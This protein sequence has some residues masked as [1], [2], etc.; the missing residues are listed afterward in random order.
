[1]LTW[2]AKNPAMSNATRHNPCVKDAAKVVGNVFMRA[3]VLVA[4][5]STVFLSTTGQFHAQNRPP[6]PPKSHRSRTACDLGSLVGLDFWDIH[7]MRLAEHQ[8]SI[9][10]AIVALAS[11]HEEYTTSHKPAVTE[12][13]LRSYSKA[14]QG[15]LDLRGNP[16]AVEV[17]LTTC[18][19]FACLESLRGFYFSCLSHLTSGLNVL[20]EHQARHMPMLTI[21]PKPHLERLLILLDSQLMDIGGTKFSKDNQIR[22]ETFQTIP[23]DFTTAEDAMSCL[24]LLY[25]RLVYFQQKC[26]RQNAETDGDKGILASLYA[27][28]RFLREDHERWDQGYSRLASSASFQR[29]PGHKANNLA[30]QLLSRVIRMFLDLDLYGAEDDFD[31]YLSDFQVMLADCE[32]FIAETARYGVLRKARRDSR[33]SESSSFGSISTSFTGKDVPNDLPQPGLDAEALPVFSMSSGCVMPLYFIAARCRHSA[34]R[35]RAAA[36]LK[37]CNRREGI[38]ASDLAG[39]IVQSVIER[40]ERT[41]NDVPQADASSSDAGKGTRNTT[42]LPANMRIRTVVVDWRDEEGGR[43]KYSLEAPRPQKVGTPIGSTRYQGLHFEELVA[44]R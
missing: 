43:A 3:Q 24:E 42:E 22:A 10:A 41:L 32:A 35:H 1:M 19:I 9:R 27:E 40:E 12:L 11:L 44:L 2:D 17:A 29:S 5:P 31:G 8:P 6:C 16:H 25:N 26:D 28:Q 13:A 33:S 30:L 39:A 38:W 20:H 4:R 14:I 34:T 21:V 15:V 37:V 23:D 18:I 7:L 36:L